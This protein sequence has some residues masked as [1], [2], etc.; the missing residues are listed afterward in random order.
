M[1]RRGLTLLV[2][3][4][5]LLGVPVLLATGGY[6]YS[7]YF[8]YLHIS[9]RDVGAADGRVTAASL[10]LLDAE[11]EVIATGSTDTV[12][13]AVR[14]DEPDFGDCAADSVAER[15]RWHACRRQRARWN[16]D[17]AGRVTALSLAAGD[18]R[19]SN[20]PLHLRV[21]REAALTWWIPLPRIGGTPDAHYFASVS[22][23]LRECR[24]VT[25]G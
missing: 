20:I 19:F 21:N 6:L 9:L 17:L 25:R 7:L 13:G 16:D 8:G 2:L 1:R 11:G 18:C 3:R 5:F 10:H 14:L 24:L 15:E 23:N 4:W 12:Y 22:L